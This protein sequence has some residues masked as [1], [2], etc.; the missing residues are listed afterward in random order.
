MVSAGV[1]W[2]G[3]VTEGESIRDLRCR[4]FRI[5][6]LAGGDGMRVKRR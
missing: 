5:D 2:G 1:G 6:D 4:K 3:A